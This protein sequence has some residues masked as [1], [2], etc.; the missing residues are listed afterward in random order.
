MK[1]TSENHG[2]C[3]VSIAP[4][5]ANPSDEAEMVSQ[6]LFGDYL[7][8]IEER[9]PWIQVKNKQDGYIGW[10]DFKQC[11]FIDAVTYNNESEALNTVVENPHL[12]IYGPDGLMTILI[13][14]SLPYS[15][16][17]T[18]ILG[19]DKY[20]LKE[21]LKKHSLKEIA[22]TFLNA[23]YLWGGKSLF[24]IDCSGLVQVIFKTQGVFVP[25]DACDQAAIGESIDWLNRKAYDLVFF[26]TKSES[27]THVGVMLDENSILHAHGKVRIDTCDHKGIFNADQDKYTHHYHS[28]KRWL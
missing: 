25:R 18:F 4:L 15:G 13:G 26:T 23:P 19:K 27:I 24:G 21:P 14:S 9:R 5:R 16:E 2:I 28:I 17:K 11:V 7:E 3:N 20:T 6:L 22:L 8:I 12:K 10:M 1:K